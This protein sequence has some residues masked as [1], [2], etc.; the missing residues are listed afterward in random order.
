MYLAL[1]RHSNERLT[2][3]IKRLLADRIHSGLLAEG[4]QLPTVRAL[5]RDLRVS[6]VT[7]MEGY[8]ALEAAGLILRHRGRGIFVS[9]R[10][11]A[12]TVRAPANDPLAWQQEVADYV[13]RAMA[14]AIQRYELP[15]TVLPMHSATISA[16]LLPIQDLLS[17]LRHAVLNDPS[18][19]GRYSPVSGD[20]RLR[21]AMAAYLNSTG[22]RVTSSEVLITQ[23]AQQGIDLVARTFVGPGDAVAVESPTYPPAIDV[24]KARGARVVPVRTDGEGLCVEALE[25]IPDLRLVYLIPTFHN[26]TGTVMSQRRRRDL[27][28]LARERRALI[29]E[30]DPW[31]ETTLDASPPPPPL[32]SLD[33]DGHVI[34]VKSVSKIVG[35][36]IRLGAVA[37]RGRL[38]RRLAAAKAISDGGA[39]LLTQLAVLPF[40]GSPRMM[41]HLRRLPGALRERRDAVLQ[42]LAVHAPRGAAWTRP[43]G[44]LSIWLTLPPGLHSDRLQARAEAGGLA[45]TSGTGFFAGEPETG[46]LRVCFGAAPPEDLSRGVALLCELIGAP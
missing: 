41:R 26:P 17:D 21:E 40:L 38:M 8:A 28:A 42:A 19:L 35:V 33:T 31:R 5:A 16:D 37:A 13:P 7:V 45:V 20:A 46:H 44:G 22:A 24:L 3:Q 6:P 29:L 10:E 15:T 39:A 34:Y 2:L 32:Q 9:R 12:P 4:E 1:D 18:L 27:L 25:E 30:D 11:S 23:G 36:G 43:A 14:G